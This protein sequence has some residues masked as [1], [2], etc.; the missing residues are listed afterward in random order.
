MSS[1]MLKV[2]MPVRPLNERPGLGSTPTPSQR[3]GPQVLNPGL[4]AKGAGN[5]VPGTVGTAAGGGGG[6]NGS[7]TVP[8]PCLP[9]R[10]GVYALTDHPGVGTNIQLTSP[11]SSDGTSISWTQGGGVCWVHIGGLLDPVLP[12]VYGAY[13]LWT[14]AYLGHRTTMVIPCSSSL[15][16]PLSTL[17][18]T[19]CSHGHGWCMLAIKRG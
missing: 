6:R 8:L 10:T 15:G 12:S 13:Q 4:G 1:C 5:L 2:V 18:E 3:S 11:R 17:S 19:Q 16:N 9:R 14:V 7:E